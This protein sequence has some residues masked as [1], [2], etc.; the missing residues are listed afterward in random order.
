MK[1]WIVV[2]D[3]E[4]GIDHY[5]FR[6]YE[7]AYECAMEYLESWFDPEDY[8]GPAENPR[9]YE[10]YVNGETIIISEIEVK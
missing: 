2:F 9:Y 1:I 4:Q 6:K 3:H 5:G 10:E 7:D 8:D